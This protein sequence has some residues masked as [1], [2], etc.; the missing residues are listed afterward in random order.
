MKFMLQV[1]ML[2]TITKKYLIKMEI[3]DWTIQN[4]DNKN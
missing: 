4:W 3:E 2:V 1:Y